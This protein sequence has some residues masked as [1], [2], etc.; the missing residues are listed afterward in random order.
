MDQTSVNCRLAPLEA[1]SIDLKERSHSP[2]FAEFTSEGA[3]RSAAA[4][5]SCSFRAAAMRRRCV[6]MTISGSILDGTCTRRTEGPL[7]CTKA[8]CSLCPCKYSMVT[9][10]RVRPSPASTLSRVPR[11]MTSLFSS[12]TILDPCSASRKT[13]KVAPDGICGANANVD[14]LS[15]NAVYETSCAPRTRFQLLDAERRSRSGVNPVCSARSN[16]EG[17]KSSVHGNENTMRG[18]GP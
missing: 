15:H 2:P 18:N 12:T 9:S 14:Q 8:I 10:E 11:T 16:A 6:A 1:S 3:T 5:R 4:R 7:K 13:P 17:D